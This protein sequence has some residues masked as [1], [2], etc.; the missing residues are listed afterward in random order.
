MKAEQEEKDKDSAA[1]DT[2][3]DNDDT[4]G[5]GFARPFTGTI[6]FE[7]TWSQPNIVK[8][9]VS[10]PLASC[11]PFIPALNYNLNELISKPSQPDVLKTRKN[12]NSLDLP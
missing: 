3:T 5:R 11:Q 9:K 7:L 10:G 1:A 2:V 8:S 6:P 4:Y 12:A